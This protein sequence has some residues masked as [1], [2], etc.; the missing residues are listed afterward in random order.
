MKN[1]K[2]NNCSENLVVVPLKHPARWVGSAIVLI[3]VFSVIKTLILNPAFQ[4]DI[5]AKYLF[6]TTILKGIYTTIQLTSVIIVIAVI[7][8]TLVAVMKLSPSKLLSLPA[9]AFIWFFRG[10]PALVQLI[11]W[12]NLSLVVRDISLTLP[13]IGTVF[14]VETN[15]FMTPFLSAV[16]GLAFHEA[17]YIA[18]IVRAGIIS[19]NEGQTEA[20]S[21]LGM[22]RTLILRRIILPQAMRLIIP[23]TGN[24]TISLLKTTSIVSVIAVTDVLYSAQIIYTR[25]FE[26]IPLLLVVTFWYL[27]VVSVLSVGQY[28]LEQ[29]FSKEEHD[30]ATRSILQIFLDSVSFGK[31]GKL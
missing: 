17:S 30:T 5:V 21:T 6:S 22:H 23:P 12:F 20:G 19:V 11:L 9:T 29:Y 4:W 28:Y 2:I 10:V 14:S 8:G 15:D 3:I 7:V 27:V 18:E 25:T 26:T 24:T 31:R 1:S 13:W 16:F